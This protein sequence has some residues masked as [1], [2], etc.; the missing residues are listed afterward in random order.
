MNWFCATSHTHFIN[1]H[2][3]EEFFEFDDCSGVFLSTTVPAVWNVLGFVVH[4][5]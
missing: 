5:P 4:Y 1:P 2:C 3:T